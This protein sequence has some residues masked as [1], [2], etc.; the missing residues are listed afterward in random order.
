MCKLVVVMLFVRREY[1]DQLGQNWITPWLN[2]FVNL[3]RNNI[4]GIR[5]VSKVRVHFRK[6]AILGTN[7]RAHS[8]FKSLDQHQIRN[9]HATDRARQTIAPGNWFCHFSSL[10]MRW[11]VSFSSTTLK[12]A[13]THGWEVWQIPLAITSIARKGVVPWFQECAESLV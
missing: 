11:R 7:M 8:H 10:R 13:S 5:A 12:E 1:E 9:D 2:L 3:V 4:T 6:S